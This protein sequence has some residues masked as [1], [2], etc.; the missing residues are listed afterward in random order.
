MMSSKRRF[1]ETLLF[2]SPDKV[3]LSPG[4][5]R[6]ST[7]AAWHKQGLA[8]GV[9][10]HQ[11]LLDALEIREVR[12]EPQEPRVDLAASFKMFPT[13][14]EKVLEHKNGHYIVRDWMG[15]I[16]EISDKYDYTY[17]RSA[18]DF[19]TRRWIKF[20]IQNHK[21]WQ[22]MKKRFSPKTTERYP[23]DFEACCKALESQD[24]P[25]ILSI[26]G[27][28]WQLREWCGME[29]LCMLMLDDSDWVQEMVN[30]WANFVSDVMA[31]IQKK[32]KI[33]CIVISEDMAYKTR[34]MI[35]PKM[36]RQF[37]L[38]VYQ[39]WIPEIKKGGCAIISLDSDGYTA[40]LIPL[41]IE[42]GI[43]CCEPME[44]AAGND[45]VSYRR[46][47]G[48]KMAYRGGIDKRA[49]AKGGQVMKREVMRVVPPLLEEG[50]FI[51]KCD[52]GVPPDISW[53]NYVEYSRLL[54]KLTG[55]L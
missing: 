44:V 5:P 47:Y 46:I 14:E 12:E 30:F 8:E 22:E 43:N 19:V 55:W 21:D 25:I 35:S 32:V 17:I 27:P 42:A 15:A 11:A 37:L 38:P 48:K 36:V 16:T 10:W 3:P 20:P 13:F 39:H 53:P 29:N 31:Q 51:P 52:H 49:I 33:D 7:L 4:E 18:K 54:A 2:G 23:E 41:W 1:R 40:E 50:G 34:S 45:I 9:N 26:N 28:F 6:E 24:Y